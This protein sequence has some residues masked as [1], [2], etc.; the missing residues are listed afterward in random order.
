MQA[1]AHLEAGRAFST[2]FPGGA[3]GNAIRTACQIA[4]NPAGV[5]VIRVT[6]NGF[7]THAGQSP[8]HAR[9]LAELSNG[10]RAL[11]LGLQELDRW[12]DTLVLTYSEF[13]RRPRENL[14]A[15]TDHGTASVQFALGGRVQGGLYG[16]APDLADLT[17]DGNPRHAVDFRSVYATVCENWWGTDSRVALGGAFAPVPFIAG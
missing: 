1:A 14:N 3:F 15:G 9:L 5:A 6:L 8:T 13:G 7:D 4:A 2:A 16:A 12:D 17:G 11:K 10:M